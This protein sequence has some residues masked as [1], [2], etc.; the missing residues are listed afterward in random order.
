[1]SLCGANK[2]Y[3]PPVVMFRDFVQQ[4]HIIETDRNE[5]NGFSNTMA[6]ESETTVSQ[7]NKKKVAMLL[8]NVKET[9]S[10]SQF[11]AHYSFTPIG[12]IPEGTALHM[13]GG[14]VRPKNSNSTGLYEEDDTYSK[15]NDF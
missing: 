1:M 8:F 11:L 7:I 5:D 12:K 4:E 6:T 2:R 9:T 10:Q 15:G 3:S 14:G 13:R